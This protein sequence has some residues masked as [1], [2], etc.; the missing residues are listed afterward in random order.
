MIQ[1]IKNVRRR[2]RRIKRK[3]IVIKKIQFKMLIKEIKI[4]FKMNYKIKKPS[5]LL[6]IFIKCYKL[7]TQNKILIN[8]KIKIKINKIVKTLKK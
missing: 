8:L 2:K 5:Y 4:L 7:K 6:K 3:I 1:K